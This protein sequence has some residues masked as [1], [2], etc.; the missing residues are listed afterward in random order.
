MAKRTGGNDVSEAF[1]LFLDTICNGF[2]GIVFIL[3]LA[4]VLLQLSGKVIAPDSTLDP[5]RIV[6]ETERI[7]AQITNLRSVRDALRKQIQALSQGSDPELVDRYS[8]A[9]ISE[10]RLK[11][12]AEEL[13]AALAALEGRIQKA[14][15]ESRR[16]AAEAAQAAQQVENLKKQLNQNPA[17][18]QLRL[19]YAHETSK[20]Q[21]AVF[22]AGGRLA[23]YMKYD[24]KGMPIDENSD[25][26]DITASGVTKSIQ[27]KPGRGMPIQTEPAMENQLAPLLSKLVATGNDEAKCHY[28]ILIVWPDSYSEA[29]RVRDLLIKKKFDY[30]LML[31]KAGDPVL[32]G[33]GGGGRGHVQ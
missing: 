14:E 6:R 5:S 24:E 13:T 25:D 11:K 16:V 27:L 17:S 8:A 29:E 18:H 7:E 23:P 20:R 3:L 10:T 30:N 22:I 2:G 32:A 15:A 19:P 31:M 12:E 1:D 9:V 4:C 33:P 26:L 28:V 21:V